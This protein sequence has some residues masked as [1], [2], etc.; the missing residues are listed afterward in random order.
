MTTST[1][2]KDWLT[3]KELQEYVLTK[4]RHWSR[5]YIQFLVTNKKLPSFKIEMLDYL[6]QKK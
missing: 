6:P 3:T 2:P 4:E 5:T 1:K